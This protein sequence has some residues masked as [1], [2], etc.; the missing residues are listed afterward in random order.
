M[1][2]IIKNKVNE[3]IVLSEFEIFIWYRRLVYFFDFWLYWNL[4][5]N[6]IGR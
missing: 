3:N 4:A 2:N 1:V 5:I 6:E